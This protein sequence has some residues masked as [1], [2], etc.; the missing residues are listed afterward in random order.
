MN[1]LIQYVL[2]LNYIDTDNIFGNTAKEIAVNMLED[3]KNK[4]LEV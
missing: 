3:F 2:P 4:F 1:F